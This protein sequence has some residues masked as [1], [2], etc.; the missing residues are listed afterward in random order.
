MLQEEIS[1]GSKTITS[2][3]DSTC[4]NAV[5]NQ[6]VVAT[7]LV[8]APRRHRGQPGLRESSRTDSNYTE[9]KPYLQ[10]TKIKLNFVVGKAQC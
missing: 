5:L 4:E 9:K 8:P 10:K 3:R 7:L 2:E 1:L 6:V